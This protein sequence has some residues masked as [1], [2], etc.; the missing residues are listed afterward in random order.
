[1]IH[2][3]HLYL[4]LLGFYLPIVQVCFLGFWYILCLFSWNLL[5]GLKIIEICCCPLEILKSMCNISSIWILSRIYS[6]GV[7]FSSFFSLAYMVIFSSN[8]IWNV[9]IKDHRGSGWRPFF[10]LSLCPLLGRGTPQLIQRPRWLESS[11]K[12][13]KPHSTSGLSFIFGSR[14]EG[15][16]AESLWILLRALLFCLSVFFLHITRIAKGSLSFSVTFRWFS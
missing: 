5:P 9:C 7:I 12:P 11:V 10:F 4:S 13:C 15:S 6:S 2:C 16:S 14:L 3:C 8:L 1:M